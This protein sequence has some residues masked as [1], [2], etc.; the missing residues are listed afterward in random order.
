[1]AMT[2]KTNLKPD[3][4]LTRELGTS[5]ER[6][7]ING[8]L[9]GANIY[10]GTCAT[11]AGTSAKAV[12]CP[13]F[14][15][16][17]LTTGTIV[18]V[19]FNN[20]NSA[21][22]AGLTLSVNGT[23]AKPIKYQYNASAS[24][25]LPAVGYIVANQTYAFSYDGTNWVTRDIHYNTNDNTQMRTYSNNANVELPIPGVSTTASSS[26]A[27]WAT[28]ST[29]RNGYGAYPSSGTPTINP[30]T[31]I[32]TVPN[33][34]KTSAFL[35]PISSGS[36]TYGKGTAGQTLLTNGTN[37]YWGDAASP[38]TEATVS[39][40]GFT[41]N[42]GTVTSIELSTGLSGGPITTSGTI[43]LD[44][45]TDSK[46]GGVIIGENISVAN[47]VISISSGNVTDA[48]GYTP[49]TTNTTYSAS[50]GL[51]LTNTSFYV[52]TAN[53]STMVNLLDT[54]SSN[55]QDNDYYI[56]QYAGGG[57]T[58]TTYHRRPHSALYNYIKGKIGITN[59]G[60][61]FLRKD[62]TWQTPVG[63]TYT[64]GTGLSLTGTQFSLD[65]VSTTAATTAAS[66]TFGGSVV[67]ITGITTNDYG[68]IIGT[69]AT[70]INIPSTTATT[71]AD[72]L[73]ASGL[74]TTID[75]IS[76]VSIAAGTG[77]SIT[78][79]AAFGTTS[80][81]RTIS[82]STVTTTA[83]TATSSPSYGGNFTA[84]SGIE[85]NSYGQV[86]KVTTK[87][88]TLPGDNNNA[89]TQTSTA[90]SAAYRVILSNAA[91]DDT[92]TAGVKKASSLTYNPSTKI[93]T[94]SGGTV[95]ATT[96]SG[97]ATAASAIAT[98]ADTTAKFWR[99]DN[100]W[101]IPDY[102]VTSVANKT[103]AVTLGTLTICGHTYDGT[104]NTT[105]N[106]EDLNLASAMDFKGITLENLSNGSTCGYL[107]MQDG[108][109]LTPLNG[110]VVL[111]SDNEEYIWNGNSWTSMGVATS[112]ALANHVHGNLSSGGSILTSATI[113]AGDRIV[114]VD[115]NDSGRL[116]GSSITFSTSTANYFL[117]QDGTWQEPRDT[118]YSAS[119]G[120]YQSGT[121]FSLATITSSN[122]TS[123]SAPNPGG[124]FTAVDAVT[125]D[126]YGR[127]T[128]VNTKT[129][130]IP[131]NVAMTSSNA[132]AYVLGTTT[133]ANGN[134]AV[135]FNTSV[136]T[137]GTILMG[138]AWND[139]AEYRKDNPEETTIQKPGRC[140]HETG[141]GSLQL[142]TQRLERGCEIISDTF[143]FAIG[144]DKENGY[145]TPIASNGRVLAYPFEDIEMF[146]T[147]IGWPVCSGPNGTVSIM[148]AEEE[149]RYPSRIVGTISEIPAY[150]EWGSGKVKV[151]GRIWIRIR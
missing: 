150:E 66:P 1:M 127:V 132:V 81:T 9:N 115:A 53:V 103:G 118:T 56:A 61:T 136:Y 117:R 106:L 102:P 79:S 32:I 84:I 151:N 70:T 89:V 42:T 74:C 39:G 139:Y 11:A 138:A 24:S 44:A 142:T 60:T 10:Y 17:A 48:L 126:T 141:D 49:P 45:A 23:T 94:V 98:A 114:I 149:E 6:W 69:T 46:I 97:T 148:T 96:F 55:P 88:I 131:S 64:A 147:H 140:V 87:T 125:Y 107:A 29:Y 135:V 58:T 145:N 101:E 51:S 143:G 72:G 50:T 113:G 65:T 41:K 133:T 120:I 33:G 52:T 18:Y 73:M 109:H 28:T 85:T 77:I 22:V 144:Q 3:A 5:T 75:N 19:T 59:T 130:T 108:S 13:A 26:S 83:A 110:N 21:A 27:A 12:T 36:T 105:I 128:S 4:D 43:F 93:L 99:G 122:P 90:T 92:E 25:A 38:V 35:A 119:T 134:K 71:T 54:G 57:T 16:S 129:I 100:T 121:V 116:T 112:Y 14:S 82:L 2:F 124:T 146:K 67:A 137:S 62:G 63:T 86:T 8:Q 76:N 95:S 80:G 47:G 15:S 37:I 68:Q 78:S 34:V 91:N 123:T 31:G 7:K 20:T 40:W 111:D 104:S 30:A